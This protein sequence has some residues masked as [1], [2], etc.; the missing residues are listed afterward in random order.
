MTLQN[1]RYIV[2]VANSR[3]FSKAAKVLFMSQSALSTAVKEVE[4]EL[5]TR[6]FL[7][8]NRGVILTADG[9]ECLKYCREIIE[10]SD[11]L[12]SLY[13]SRN[14]T[15]TSFSVSSQH[16]PFAM[17]AYQ[18]LM[19]VM[20]DEYNAAIRE[21]NTS[22]VLHDVSS[23]RSELG[24]VVFQE[25]QLDLM[26]RS[27]F[28]HDLQFNE[29]ANLSVFVFVRKLH[30][31]AASKSLS[32]RDLQEYP[33]VT[34]DQDETPNYYSEEFCSFL[35]FKKH[36]HVSDR[37][38]KMFVIRNSDSFSIGVD[39]PNFNLDAFFRNRVP[40]IET[41][42][43]TAI[44]LADQVLPAKVGYLIKNGHS[45][46]LL[47]EEYMKLLNKQIELLQLPMYTAT[48]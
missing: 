18:E 38:T 29:L 41:V 31:L 34:Y 24:I 44:P 9:E 3:S 14:E 45:P 30:P 27:L 47:A 23:D 36:I 4:D 16:L 26:R 5:G 39:L 10:R 15:R 28:I 48:E 6:I 11:Y 22:A 46:G 20:P 17:R 33:F 19:S 42:Q 21:G 7:R 43:M 32:L 37:A 35:S 13:H 1:L 25:E 40:E 8:T 12:L 2:E